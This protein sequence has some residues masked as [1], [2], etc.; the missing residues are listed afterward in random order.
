MRK[1]DPGVAFFISV[2][3]WKCVGRGLPGSGHVTDPAAP[4]KNPALAGFYTN[5]IKDVI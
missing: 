3:R 4:S 1:G 2:R 5:Q